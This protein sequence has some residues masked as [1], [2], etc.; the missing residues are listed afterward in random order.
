[1]DKIVAVIPI[2]KGSE[3]IPNKNFKPFKNSKSLLELKIEN[4]KKIKS[5]DKIIVNTDSKK[6]INI[7]KK[8]NI[9]FYKREKYYASSKCSGSD[10]FKN[11]AETTNAESILY[12]PCTS[13][14]ISEETFINCINVFNSS[15]FNSVNS[16]TLVREFLWL[17][18]MALNYNPLKSPNSQNLPN[19]LKLN[20]G[21]NLISKKEMIKRKNIVGSNPFFYLTKEEESIDIDIKNDFLYAQYLAHQ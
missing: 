16:V 3:R 6:A 15:P 20:F 4:L 5:I 9:S 2:R 12:A 8:Y 14:F 19:V 21:F 7:A 17:D 10:F 18:N 11:I 13:P 1:M